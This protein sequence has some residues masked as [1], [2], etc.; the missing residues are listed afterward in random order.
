MKKLKTQIT[1]PTSLDKAWDFFSSPGNL[2]E[3]TPEDMDFRI[4]S[5]VP[6]TMYEG[7]IITY[8]IKP[9][10]GIPMEWVTEITK[11]RKPYL[12]IDEQRKGPY[13]FWHHEHHFEEVDGGVLMTDILYYE[14]GKGPLGPI[15]E[16]VF[17][18]RKVRGIFDY[19]NKKLQSLFSGQAS[20]EASEG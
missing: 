11:I 9:F 13:K 15:A 17:V 5:D 8:V 20:Y 12:F 7:L 3:I 18:D 16:T 10:M 19:R 2:N 4:T 1:L 6:D 14:V